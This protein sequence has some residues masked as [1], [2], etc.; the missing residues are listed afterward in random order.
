MNSYQVEHDKL[1]RQDETVYN[2]K[3]YFYGICYYFWKNKNV[4]V[5]NIFVGN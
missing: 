3:G 4:F 2:G 1:Q 5:I